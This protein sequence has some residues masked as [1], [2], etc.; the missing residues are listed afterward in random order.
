MTTLNQNIALD[1]TESGF[2]PD[3]IIRHGIRRLLRQ[4]LNEIDANNL[5]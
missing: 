2:L 3:S 1:L 4:R 5:E